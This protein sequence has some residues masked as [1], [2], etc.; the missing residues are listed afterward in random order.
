M[1]QRMTVALAVMALAAL[2]VAAYAK[3]GKPVKSVKYAKTWEAAVEEAKELNVPIVI[4]YHG[5]Y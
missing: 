2:A 4:H 5:Y 1:I 3:G